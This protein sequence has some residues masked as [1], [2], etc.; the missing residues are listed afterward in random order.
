[1][2]KTAARLLDLRA[3]SDAE[4]GLILPS[5]SSLQCTAA[6]Q[7]CPRHLPAA[8]ADAQHADMGWGHLWCLPSLRAGGAC[9][10]QTQ[11]VLGE[12]SPEPHSVPGMCEPQVFAWLQGAV[13]LGSPQQPARHRNRSVRYQARHRA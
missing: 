7:P 1:M 4:L 11:Q 3:Y 10:H 12:G 5:H 2:R 6:M 13:R 8:V 9:R